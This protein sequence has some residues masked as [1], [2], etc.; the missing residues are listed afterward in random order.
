MMHAMFMNALYVTAS[1]SYLMT[2]LLNDFSHPKNLSTA[3]LFLL[4]SST[5]YGPGFLPFL[6]FTGMLGSY[7][8]G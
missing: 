3:D 6:G 1:L 8:H 2:I 5:L 4:Y 7:T